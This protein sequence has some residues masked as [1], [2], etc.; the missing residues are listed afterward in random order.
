MPFFHVETLLR[1][2]GSF[3]F[4]FVAFLEIQLDVEALNQDE[5]F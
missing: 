1:M 3:L 2:I 4:S 5:D